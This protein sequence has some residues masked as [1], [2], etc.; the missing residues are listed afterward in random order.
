VADYLLSIVVPVFNEVG[1]V[2]ALHERLGAVL[3]TLGCEWET[4][5]VDDGST[6]G[7][8]QALTKLQQ[9]DPRVRVIGL[10]R[11]FG[12]QVALTAGLD[13]ARGDAVICM[14]GDLQ[15][16][17]EVIPELVARWREGYEVVQTLRVETAG[18]SWFK[19]SSS[20]MFY[21]LIGWLSD[22]PISANAA[23]F[24]LMSRSA[25]DALL[26][27]RER[28]RFVR[29][30]VSWIGFRRAEVPFRADERLAGNSNYSLARMARF[31]FDALTSFSTRPLRF[32]TVVGLVAALLGA[33][34]AGYIIYIRLFTTHAVQGWASVTISVLI[35]GGL[36]LVCLGLIAEYIARLL[37]EAKA[38]PLYI[39]KGPEGKGPADRAT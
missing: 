3:A 38:R 10:S 19:T 20:R 7:T 24:R 18:A 31:A 34:Y 29:G 4:L 25:L 37:N 17:P 13:A 11:N 12:H 9:Q 15:H 35:L 14:D 32:A 5:F 22:T 2:A 16:P 23:D 26:Q 28:D 30:L 33:V 6:D 21:R 36:Q 27:C 39:V 8:A 1:N